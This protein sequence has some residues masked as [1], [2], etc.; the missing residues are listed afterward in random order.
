MNIYVLRFTQILHS[1]FCNL[2]FAI[3][4]VKDEKEGGFASDWLV[5]I[6]YVSDKYI[7][8][9]VKVGSHQQWSFMT[10]EYISILNEVPADTRIKAT[11]ETFHDD[12]KNADLRWINKY[13]GTWENGA[14]SFCSDIVMYRYPDVL[15]FDAE[16]CCEENDLDGALASL[17]QVAQRAYGEE[18]YYKTASKEDILDDILTERL[19]EFCGEGKI[20]WDYIR[21]GV[22]FDRVASLEGKENNKNILLWPVAQTALNLNDNLE[23]TE[24]EY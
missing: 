7:E 13:A 1:I 8:N 5:P 16:I 24:I 19:K 10:D 15:L 17:N 14:R 4:M 22:V 9:P 21:M 18:D 20:W 11:Y 23:Q 3:S 12:E 2:I 6:Q